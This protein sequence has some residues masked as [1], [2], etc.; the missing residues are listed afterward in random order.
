[1]FNR[2]WLA[3]Q[4]K[5]GVDRRRKPAESDIYQTFNCACRFALVPTLNQIDFILPVR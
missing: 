1:M 4:P 3:N 2:A 5:S